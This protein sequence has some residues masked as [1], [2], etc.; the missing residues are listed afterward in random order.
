MPSR[1]SCPLVDRAAPHREEQ[2]V[3][4]RRHP[5]RGRPPSFILSSVELG[6]AYRGPSPGFLPAD[7]GLNSA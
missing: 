2:C 7:N 4:G 5:R 6:D 1:V 3:G